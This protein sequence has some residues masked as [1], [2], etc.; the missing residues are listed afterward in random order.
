MAWMLGF[1]LIGFTVHQLRML[2]KVE[3]KATGNK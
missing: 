2:S 3:F 1:I